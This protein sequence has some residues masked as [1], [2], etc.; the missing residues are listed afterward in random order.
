MKLIENS[1][2]VEVGIPKNITNLSQKKIYLN[3]LIE[4]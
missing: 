4:K 2:I 1:G 3:I